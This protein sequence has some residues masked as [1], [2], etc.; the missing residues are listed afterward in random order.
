[1]DASLYVAKTGLNAQQTRMNVV[2]NN[3]ANVN[4]VGFK[5]DRPCS[6]IYFTSIVRPGP[7]RCRYCGANRFYARNG[8]QGSCFGENTGTGQ[9]DLNRKLARYSDRGAGPLSNPSTRRN[10]IHQGWQFYYPK[11]GNW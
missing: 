2:A 7:D 5:K 11:R 8:Q 4:T 10:F 9:H 3:L 1:M 6:R